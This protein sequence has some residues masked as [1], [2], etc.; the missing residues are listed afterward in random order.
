M[1]LR[2]VQIEESDAGEEQ[3]RIEGQRLN[4]LIA[5]C[6]APRCRRQTLLAYFGEQAEACG[7]C[8]LCL[9][10]V[11][12]IDATVEAQKALSAV[13]RTGERFGTEHLIA[14]LRGETTDKVLQ[15]SHDRLPTFGVGK[16][17]SKN[18]WRSI[19]RQLYGAG[20][21]ALDVGSYGR[22]MVTPHGRSV[23][24]GET[25]V[26]LRREAMTVPISAKSQRS[27]APRP[28]LDAGDQPLFDA[29]KAARQELAK[30]QRVPAYVIF[31]D[32]SLLDMVHLKPQTRDQMSLVHGV[33]KS[34]LEKY[35]DVFLRVIRN[36]RPASDEAA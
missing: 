20:V 1:R 17:H 23:L 15:F 30:Q 26:E 16:D 35:G 18:E 33:G 36:H 32:R 19:F 31:A 4:A 29:L 14:I 22:W 11:E 34:K 8:D 2:R 28:Q 7:N 5:L 9:E 12:R 13:L 10:G 6:E 27:S 24:K 3:K 21:M 25:R